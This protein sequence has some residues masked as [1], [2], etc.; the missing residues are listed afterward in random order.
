M[1]WGITQTGLCFRKI[2]LPRVYRLIG[3][4]ICLF[5]KCSFSS[6][7]CNHG[8]LFG[9][10]FPI[11]QSFLPSK[12]KTGLILL[13][14]RDQMKSGV[15]RIVRSGINKAFGVCFY[16]GGS[17]TVGYEFFGEPRSG[18][19]KPQHC[20]YPIHSLRLSR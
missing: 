4:G 11:P 16:I 6:W 12:T 13:N 2:I 17:Q 7:K 8:R 10:H 20:I 5:L 14:T 15:F 18:C 1:S 9:C 19:K 3:H